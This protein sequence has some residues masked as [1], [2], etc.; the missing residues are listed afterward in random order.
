MSIEYRDEQNQVVAA[1]S[2]LR[3][4]DGACLTAQKYLDQ[5]PNLTAHVLT[6]NSEIVIRRTTEW[7]RRNG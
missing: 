7:Q 4:K 2:R 3:D 5:F 6:G 1:M